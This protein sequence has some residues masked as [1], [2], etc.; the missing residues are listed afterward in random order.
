MCLA[1]GTAINLKALLTLSAIETKPSP[2][3]IGRPLALVEELWVAG[4]RMRCRLGHV[5]GLPADLS[6]WVTFP[7]L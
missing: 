3:S 2:A 6:G 4:G 1:I 7:L 5:P